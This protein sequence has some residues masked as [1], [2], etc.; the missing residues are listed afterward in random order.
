MTRRGPS[1][2]PPLHAVEDERLQ[3]VAV[4]ETNPFG[5]VI[6]LYE[7]RDPQIPQLEQRIS[8]ALR[9]SRG[10]IVNILSMSAYGGQP[11]LTPYSVS[12]GALATLTR[13]AGY[14]LMRNRVHVNQLDIGWMASDNE[15]K[16]QLEESGDPDW[17]AKQRQGE[18]KR[19]LSSS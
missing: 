18:P 19:P 15:R 3:P 10:S 16:I 13:H 14:A 4:L 5:N 9:E 2:A 1:R 7:I 11:S 8:R 6:E 12:K 17:E